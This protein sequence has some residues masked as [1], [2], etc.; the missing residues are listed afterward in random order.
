MNPGTYAPTVHVNSTEKT[1]IKVP[2]LVLQNNGVH[3][4]FLVGQ[5]DGPLGLQLLYTYDAGEFID[6][7]PP[8]DH[9]FG[10]VPGG[11][12]PPAP[13]YPPVTGAFLSL[14]AIGVIVGA[15][16]IL[17]GGIGFWLTRN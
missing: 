1:H 2:P 17:V 12:N 7:Y 11:V 8:P 14:R 6:T 16:L 13:L 9:P 10:N 15:A 5:M 3:T 4:I